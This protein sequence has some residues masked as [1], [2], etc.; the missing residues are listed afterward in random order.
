MHSQYRAAINNINNNNKKKRGGGEGRNRLMN[1]LSENG[2]LENEYI[3]EERRVDPI[4][5]IG[6]ADEK[7]RRPKP[8]LQLFVCAYFLTGDE[9]AALHAPDMVIIGRMA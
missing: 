7:S 8:R 5:Y 1:L 6:T 4:Q 9:C 2:I 3:L